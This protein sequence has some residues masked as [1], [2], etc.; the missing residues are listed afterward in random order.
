VKLISYALVGACLIAA[1]GRGRA[2]EPENLKQARARLA[3][4]ENAQKRAAR[5]L[6]RA[7]AELDELIAAIRAHRVKV[8][9]DLMAADPVRNSL[10]EIRT[11]HLPKVEKGIYLA[12]T[13]KGSGKE[14]ASALGGVAREQDRLVQ[15]LDGLVRKLNRS[16]ATGACLHRA[17]KIL[18][19]QIKLNA[20]VKPVLRMGF[21]KKLAGL[22]ES[23]RRRL[24]GLAEEQMRIG[25]EVE[26]LA[27]EVKGAIDGGP[28]KQ[29]PGLRSALKIISANRLVALTRQ[30]SRELGSNNAA[31]LT[32]GGKLEK[33]FRAVLAA[34]QAAV[35]GEDEVPAFDLLGP[36]L[37]E[38]A[39]KDKE[40]AEL[41]K[42][43]RKLLKE[44]ALLKNDAQPEEFRKI[45]DMQDELNNMLVEINDKMPTVENK[46]LIEKLK[47]LL[48]QALLSMN[49]S[50]EAIQGRKKPEEIMKELKTTLGHIV[51]AEAELKALLALL[52]SMNAEKQAGQNEES[53]KETPAGIA[54][55]LGLK[56]G[57]NQS[58]N[59]GPGGVL[60]PSKKA[61]EFG[62]N[63]WGRLPPKVREQLMQ[64][65]K[66][67]YTPGFEDLIDLYY[68]MIAK[69]AK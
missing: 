68:Q 53:L 56:L 16:A 44:A 59:S 38:L 63:D 2:G 11:K 6:A 31:G 64:A 58:G 52:A 51:L 30:G 48:R 21:G 55:G 1:V 18:N 32:T 54:L 9:G 8:T 60:N 45:E 34:L 4:E 13:G 26:T 35:A 65:A 20:D 7:T 19:D 17:E 66:E 14:L 43:L 5:R 67:K 39:G 50:G 49:K 22:P 25:T 46:E 40:L 29:K 61:R 28:E 36:S 24:L 57:G 12:R 41:L 15:L 47:E 69:G 37:A 62:R 33:Y 3:R 27:K 10:G 23:L 42:K